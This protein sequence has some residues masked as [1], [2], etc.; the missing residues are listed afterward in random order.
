M[1][2][3]E[4]GNFFLG[5][6]GAA[7]ALIGLLFVV[8]AIDPKRTI[9]ADAPIARRA[10]AGSAF[11]A[12]LNAF[13]VSLGSLLP[14]YNLGGFALVMSLIGLLNSST[15][16]LRIVK[17]RGSGALL[18]QRALLLLASFIIYGLECANGIGLINNG[19][20]HRYVYTIGILLITIYGVALSRAWELLGAD[21]SGL[22][23]LIDVL[24]EPRPRSESSPNKASP[25]TP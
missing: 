12:L 21:E 23:G 6:A 13:F 3:A 18:V 9:G 24:R 19:N 7:A 8:V 10:I 15:L 25:P 1:V 20:D 5:S 14:G 22:R 11:T 4:Y 2:P 17:Q 16:V